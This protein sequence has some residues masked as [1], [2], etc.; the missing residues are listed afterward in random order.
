MFSWVYQGQ[1]HRFSRCTSTYTAAHVNAR[2]L[3][4]YSHIP[5]GIMLTEATIPLFSQEP[6][7]MLSDQHISPCR[8]AS[9]TLTLATGWVTFEWRATFSQ[10]CLN[11]CLYLHFKGADTISTND[12]GILKACINGKGTKV[13]LYSATQLSFQRIAHAHLHAAPQWALYDYGLDA[14]KAWPLDY[15]PSYPETRRAQVISRSCQPFLPFL[16]VCNFT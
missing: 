3:T 2:A 8:S 13:H 14:I 4:C 10:G 1:V 15:K 5:C 9:R 16:I 6:T 12:K 11:Q 7:L